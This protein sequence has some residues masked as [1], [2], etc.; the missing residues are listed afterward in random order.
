MPAVVDFL[1][2]HGT[3]RG[4]AITTI[5]ACCALLIRALFLASGCVRF[6][7]VIYPIARI[8][9]FVNTGGY[10]TGSRSPLVSVLA[11]V[12]ARITFLAGAASSIRLVGCIL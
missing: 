8:R 7:V 6:F 12:R 5:I 2:S 10:I 11:F 1:R 9:L 4:L 3:G